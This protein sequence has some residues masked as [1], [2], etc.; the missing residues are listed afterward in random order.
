VPSSSRVVRAA[1]AESVT[2]ASSRG[3]DVRLSPTQTESKYPDASART[4]DSNRASGGTPNSTARF[5]RL[6]PNFTAAAR[7]DMAPSFR[8]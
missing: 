8:S 1:R 6:R 3:R 5:G 2:I 7:R 4:A